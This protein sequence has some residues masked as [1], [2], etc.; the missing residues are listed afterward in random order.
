MTITLFK[1]ILNVWYNDAH[2]VCVFI[3]V[4]ALPLWIHFFKAAIRYQ[5]CKHDTLADKRFKTTLSLYMPDCL[6][7]LS[8][9]SFLFGIV[10]VGQLRM[11]W[12]IDV[13]LRGAGAVMLISGLSVFI[14]FSKQSPELYVFEREPGKMGF[15]GIVRHPYYALLLYISLGMTLSAVSV[16]SAGVLVVQIIV[17]TLCTGHIGKVLIAKDEYFIDYKYAAPRLVPG[18]ADMLRGI[19]K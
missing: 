11:S 9:I 14:S 18:L 5:R 13:I 1:D 2:R 4:F 7:I 15:Y 8:V 12:T 16:F 19:V 17:S 3:A 6:F 10:G